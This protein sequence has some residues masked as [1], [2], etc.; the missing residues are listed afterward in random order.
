MMIPLQ[1]VDLKPE[2]HEVVTVESQSIVLILP[3]EAPHVF[4][5][6]STALKNGKSSFMMAGMQKQPDAAQSLSVPVLI[7]PAVASSTL[8]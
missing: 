2:V 8:A 1:L 4:A 7:R 5:I 3:Y 6:S